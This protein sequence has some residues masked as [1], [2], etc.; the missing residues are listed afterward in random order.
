MGRETNFTDNTQ[1]IGLDGHVKKGMEEGARLKIR[2]G[3]RKGRK[4]W[5]FDGERRIIIG[6]RIK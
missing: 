4:Q 1:V 2:A 3:I 6:E 5:G